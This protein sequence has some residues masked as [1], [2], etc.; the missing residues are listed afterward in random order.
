MNG[1]ETPSHDLKFLVATDGIFWPPENFPKGSIGL[2]QASVPIPKASDKLLNSDG[3]ESIILSLIENMNRP[4]V[5][6]TTPQSFFTHGQKTTR[7]GYSEGDS[8]KKIC[9]IST[10]LRGDYDRDCLTYILESA[11]LST[12][13]AFESLVTDL[14]VKV[15]DIGPKELAERILVVLPDFRYPSMVFCYEGIWYAVD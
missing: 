12:W 9:Q 13:T 2:Y 7:N 3:V 15:V 10:T 14:W 5:L 6:L 4:L 8:Y 1:M 11:A